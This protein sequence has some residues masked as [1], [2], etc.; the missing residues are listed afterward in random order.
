MLINLRMRWNWRTD[1]I[2]QQKLVLEEQ[3][4]SLRG[5][6][7]MKSR[8]FANISHEFRTPLNL[9]MGPIQ[10]ILDGDYGDLDETLVHRH[11]VMLYESKRLLRLIN[12]MLDL[13]KLEAGEIDIELQPHDL[14]PLWKRIVYS[15][16]SRPKWSK[17]FS[18]FTLTFHR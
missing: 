10:S 15:F 8:F 16:S 4:V 18:G 14:I 7:E 1:E 2:R 3:A 13:S 17:R 9:I 6:N 11:Q 12:Q 5:L